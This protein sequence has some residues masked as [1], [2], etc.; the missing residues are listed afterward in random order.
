MNSAFIYDAVRTPRGKGREGGALNGVTPVELQEQLIAAVLER[1]DCTPGAIDD[2]ILGCVTQVGEQG[3]NIA[4]VAALYSGLPDSVSGITIN[5]YCTSGLDACNFAAMKVMTGADDVVLAGGV[6]SMSR[7]AMLSDNASFY[8]DPA[9][10]MKAGFVPM[11]LAADLVASLDGISRDE[12]DQYAVRSQQRAAAAQQSGAFSRSLVPLGNADQD[13]SVRGSVTVE[14]LATFD[15]LFTEFG[16]QG[17]EAAFKAAF[18]ELDELKYV[19]HAG[20]SPGIVDGASLVF[21]GSE[22]SGT[23]YGLTPRA[24][25][26]TMTNVSGDKFLALTGGIDAANDVLKKAGMSA[27]DV[28]LV[29]FNEA[30]ASVSIKFTRDTEWNE[31]QVN[32][33]GGAIALGHAMGATGASLV[34]TVLD[35][36][37]RRDLNVGLVAVS[38]AAGIGTATL[39]ERV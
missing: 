8:T 22:K 39:I 19:H 25:I 18:T 27:N 28:D 32:V 17:Y 3:G 29:E 16:R 34:G 5:R 4:K 10:V 23:D 14:K 11:G 13:E 33:N 31:D 15:P 12:C 2:I 36:L 24:R 38:G 21:I 30:F 26:K 6:E 9:V 20:N 35:E 37:E 1:N 7:V